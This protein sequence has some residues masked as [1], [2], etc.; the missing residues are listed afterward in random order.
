VLGSKTVGSGISRLVVAIAPDEQSSPHSRH[1]FPHQS[2][3]TRRGWAPTVVAHLE[4]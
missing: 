4:Q 3:V 2:I 1:P